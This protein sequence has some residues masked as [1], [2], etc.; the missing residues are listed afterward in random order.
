MLL[1]EF[2]KQLCEDQFK[3]AMD[4]K[5][6]GDQAD[7]SKNTVNLKNTDVQEIKKELEWWTVRNEKISRVQK[8]LQK[9]TIQRALAFLKVMGKPEAGLFEGQLEQMDTFLDEAQDHKKFLEGIYRHV[10]VC[11]ESPDFHTITL[12]LRKVMKT[13]RNAWMLSKHYNTDEKLVSLIKRITG[14]LVSRVRAV[15]VVDN[16]IHLEDMNIKATESVK[17][18]TEWEKAF[19]LTREEIEA[20]GREAR[21]EFPV[22]DIFNE[23]HHLKKISNDVIE[24][25]RK[26]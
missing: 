24:V 23:I 3:G 16:F 17:L 15:V 6:Q 14:I 21:W 18:L 4:Q 12:T 13:L 26:I 5:V 2:L 11:I 9:P 7:A 25:R 20:S 22:D 19:K 10:R 8:E 1:G